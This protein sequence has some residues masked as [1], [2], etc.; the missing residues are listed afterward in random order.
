MAEIKF[1]IKENIGVLQNCKK[2][3]K[4]TT[5]SADGIKK[6]KELLNGLQL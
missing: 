2:M 3:G 6:L 4:G 5:L 1:E